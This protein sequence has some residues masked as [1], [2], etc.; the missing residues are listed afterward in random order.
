MKVSQRA[1]Q[2]RPSL[3]RKLFNMAQSYKDV[4][5]LTLGDPDFDPPVVL[6]NA[7]C[8]A[9]KEGKT[10]YS[11]NAGLKKAREAVAMHVERIWKVR[12]QTDEIIVTV[13]GMEALYLALLCLIDPGDEVIVFAPYYVNYSDVRRDSCHS[14]QLYK[15]ERI[16]N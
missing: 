7:A 8:R 2:I 13:G 10:H 1:E 9:I 14:G 3:T 6:K 11:P 12:R 16:T 5:D 4:V 15:R